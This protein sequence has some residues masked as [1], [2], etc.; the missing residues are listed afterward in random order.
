MNIILK[1]LKWLGTILLFSV[2]V[3]VAF[4]YHNQAPQYE[5]PYPLFQQALILTSLHEVNTYF[6]VQ[7]I[8]PA[9]R[10]LETK[11]QIHSDV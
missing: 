4:I 10:H 5:A 6:T 2:L 1:M 11:L 8:A 9:V 7:H 3:A